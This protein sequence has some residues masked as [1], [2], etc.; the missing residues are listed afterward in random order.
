[1]ARNFMTQGAVIEMAVNYF[2]SFLRS[3]QQAIHL[4]KWVSGRQSELDTDSVD[5]DDPMFGLPYAPRA[6]DTTEEYDNLRGLAPNAFAGLIVTTLA[7]TAYV[8]GISRR[9]VKGTLPAWNTWQRNRWDSKQIPVHRTAIGL[10][11]AF[12][13]VLPGKDPLTGAKMSK[14]LAKSPKS[15]AAFY[16]NDDDEW[17]VIAIEAH[18]VFDGTGL[19]RGIQT[20]WLVTVYDEYVNHRLECKSLGGSSTD[21]WTYIDYTEHGLPV[22]PVARLANRIDLDGR[23]TGEIEPV[24]PLLRRIDQDTF[25]RLIVQRFGAWQ[26]RYI[27]GMAKPS[28]KSEAAAQ[29]LRLKVEDILISTNKD[30]K[31]GVLQGSPL[32]PF[33]EATD[34]D[35]R[36]LAAITQTPPHHLLGLSSNLQA[37]ALAAAESGLQRKS[38]DFKTNAGE[39]HE[40]M[41]RLSAMAEGDMQTAAAFD[42]QIRWRDTESR[43]MTQAADALG[44]L[45]VQ[46]KVP[47]EMLWERIPGWTDTD[48]ARAK[49]LVADGSFER[50]VQELMD[51]TAGGN[52]DPNQGQ[53][54]Q[55]DQ[56]G[57]TS[58][59]GN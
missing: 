16:D 30:T 6:E 56:Q 29:K 36:L 10:A 7:Q 43:S 21:D 40:Q 5:S 24:L 18:P 13:T 48:V 55:Q 25:D 50:L 41:A 23:T 17:P 51:G 20:G 3:R 59:N 37:E 58:G 22:P 15:M 9:G 39:F 2:P 45:A 57:S 53:G 44:K 38:H 28:S 52:Q 8:E 26:V 46:L 31:F 47:L 11:Q 35:L 12:G 4:D 27:A 32:G 14:M 33:I 42:L 19:T 34:A 1:M 49:D 54:Q